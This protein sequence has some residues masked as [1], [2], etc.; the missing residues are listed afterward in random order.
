[1]QDFKNVG[2]WQKAHA[3]VLSVYR[4]TQTM[5][6]E[7]V[8][9]ITTQLR[10]GA[11]NVATRI[12]E[13]CGRSS[14]VDFAVDL[15]RAVASSNELEY[16]MLLTRDLGYWKPELCEQLTENTIEVRKMILGILRKL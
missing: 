11:T 9:G 10:R 3:L 12:A 1:M 15:R 4:E 8:F 6:R 5:P 2:A 7:E 16:L 14:D 13:G